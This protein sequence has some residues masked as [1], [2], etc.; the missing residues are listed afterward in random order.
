MP[1]RLEESWRASASTKSAS[2]YFRWHAPRGSF[3]AIAALLVTAMGPP[4][5]FRAPCAHRKILSDHPCP[6][7][8]SPGWQPVGHAFPASNASPGEPVLCGSPAANAG[9]QAVAVV[10]RRLRRRRE[11]PR[12][13]LGSFV[14]VFAETRLCCRLHPRVFTHRG[15]FPGARDWN[16]RRSRCTAAKPRD[17]SNESA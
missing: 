14:T 1:G 7:M 13:V 11:P 12:V 10:A 8:N 15:D 17:I 6:F 4:F 3:A 16:R 5:R 9:C 2:A